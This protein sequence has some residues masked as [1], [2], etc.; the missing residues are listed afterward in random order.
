MRDT[1][2]PQQALLRS[3]YVTPV[4]QCQCLDQTS[5]F[6][7]VA[8]IINA[9][10]EASAPAVYA[11]PAGVLELTVFARSANISRDIDSVGKLPCFEIGTCRIDSP[12]RLPQL[13]LEFPEFPGNRQPLILVPAETGMTRHRSF[14]ML[15]FDDVQEQADTPLIQP[16]DIGNDSTYQCNTIVKAAVKP[17]F[18]MMMKRGATPEIGS[19]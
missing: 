13:H 18:E 15:D 17:V 4:S 19:A 9:S 1:T 2:G 6:T 8:T 11:P 7:S 14:V 10:S 16:G 5:V 3:R 12:G